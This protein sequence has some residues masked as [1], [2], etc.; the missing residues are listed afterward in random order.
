MV[1]RSGRD[2]LFAF[3]VRRFGRPV[4]EGQHLVDVGDGFTIG[5]SAFEPAD[6]LFVGRV[7]G[8]EAPRGTERNDELFPLVSLDASTQPVVDNNASA[9]LD[10]LSDACAHGLD[11]GWKEREVSVERIVLT[12]SAVPSE[13]LFVD[14]ESRDTLGLEAMCDGR[15]AAPR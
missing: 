13:H 1:R 6:Q 5:T 10:F 9:R 2:V 15:F 11:G 8:Q 4:H 12:D 14:R 7:D 3:G